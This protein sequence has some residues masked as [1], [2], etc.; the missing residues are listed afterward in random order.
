MSNKLLIVI[1][2][3]NDF[4]TGSLKNENAVKI[5]PNI[6]KK[7][8]DHKGPIIATKDTHFEKTEK[9]NIK[10][11]DTLE[12]KLLPVHHAIKNTKGWEIEEQIL[13][14]LKK[15]KDFH[16]IEKKTF[17][18]D[19]WKDYLKKFKFN[20]IEICGVVA[21]ICVISNSIILRSLFPN[22]KIVVDT[23]AI[24]D[25]NDEGFNST[26]NILKAQQIEVV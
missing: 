22:M 8:K 1:D 16:E 7:I 5:I 9:D 2:M 10:Y 14:E 21:S 24:A 12:G 11:D 23:K 6:I 15:H 19:G 4:L 25:I 13:N 26:V 3:Q 18:W 20:E 17:G